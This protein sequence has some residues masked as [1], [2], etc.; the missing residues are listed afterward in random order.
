[1]KFKRFT[2]A[3]KIFTYVGLSSLTIILIAPLLWLTMSTFKDSAKI[4][5]DP[6]SL[7]TSLSFQNVSDAWSAGNFGQLL[8]NSIEITTI[9]VIG[10]LIIEGLAAY[11]LS[12]F[13]FR[14]RGLIFVTFVVGQFVPAQVIMLPSSLQMSWL[15]LSD[16]KTA[17]I[18]QYLSW[19]PVAILFLSAS[20]A[21]VPRELE[22]AAMVD[23]AGK[24]RILTRIV[25]PL[26][27]PAFVSV[28]TIYALSIYNDFVFPL[29]YI[30]SPENATVPLGLAS[31]QNQFN[32]YWGYLI[33]AIVIGIW[34]PLII[35]SIFSRRVQGGFMTGALKG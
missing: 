27:R 25:L 35:Y 29:M 4:V 3:S 21:T 33:G 20:M 1:M 23:G 26:T 17:L 14:A 8:I 6:F 28:A 18:L 10:I 9:S 16:T 31:F 7:P 22:E 30:R 12:R 34:P 5:G 11:P 15:G 2:L 32:S 13:R 24:I 19:A